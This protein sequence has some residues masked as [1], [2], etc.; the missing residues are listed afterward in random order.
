MSFY[1][2]GDFS[3][4]SGISKDTLRYYDKA[5]VLSPSYKAENGYRYY[6][7]YDLMRLMQIR[8]L[9]GLDSS[10]EECTQITAISDM[11]SRLT[12]SEAEL[13]RQIAQLTNLRDRIH[14]LQT[15]IE[16][17]L[18]ECGI[19]HECATI[20][21]YAVT[22]DHSTEAKRLVSEWMQ[23]APYSHLSFCFPKLIDAPAPRLMIGILKDYA[24]AHHLDVSGAEVR[25]AR[26]AVRCVLKLQDPM[27]PTGAE[28]T[29]LTD[30]MK[31]HW[32]R[33]AGPWTYRLRFIDQ[34]T[35]S[36]PVYYVGAC[37][38]V[39]PDGAGA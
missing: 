17:C 7:E 10:L 19:C 33:P 25:P 36:A 23:H 2:I 28:L 11:A 27:H 16:N 38:P 35:D 20:A 18:Q 5:G 14:M 8:T 21:T 32:L 6:T 15:E 24:Q 31:M 26:P 9:R 39:A 12:T 34:E 29:P 37:V 30:Y 13:N 22:L 3:L 4:L 1:R